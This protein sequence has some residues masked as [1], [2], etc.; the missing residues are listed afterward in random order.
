MVL[1]WTAVL[2]TASTILHVALPAALPAPLPAAFSAPSNH[3]EKKPYAFVPGVGV[4][5]GQKEVVHSTIKGKAVPVTRF[6]GIPYAQNPPQRFAAPQPLQPAFQFINATMYGPSCVQP[7][8][9]TSSFANESRGEQSESCLHL[10]IIKPAQARPGS[11]LP[12]M[13]WIYGGNLALGDASLPQYN[14]SSI[15]ANQDVIFVSFNYRLNIFGFSRSP[16]VPLKERNPGFLD[17]RL[18]LE[19]VRAN[20][21]AFGGCPDKVTVFGES[22]GGFSIQQLLVYPQKPL[23]YR[24][25]ILESRAFSGVASNTSPWDQAV[26][27]LGCTGSTSPLACMRSKDAQE[28]NKKVGNITFGPVNDNTTYA[29]HI[30]P[31]IA[32]GQTAK[33]P[34][35]L[36]TN[37]NEGTVLTGL[38]AAPPQ[39]I[40]DF[41]FTC[42]TG[43]LAAD[44]Q[45]AS[46]S[47]WRYYF[48][49]SFPNTTPFPDAGAYHSSEIPEVFGTYPTVGATAQQVAL[50]EYMQ[51]A[52]ARFAKDPVHGP[53]KDWPEYGSVGN[54]KDLGVNGSSSGPVIA[55]AS[56][57]GICAAY[58]GLITLQG[59]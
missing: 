42:T 50:S 7:V 21:V 43:L 20:I 6:L 38:V 4:L 25:V 28:I 49:A 18:A 29:D 12:V 14:G 41:A 44:L 55:A 19:W 3:W 47:V 27:S 34:V 22:A 2:L 48:N 15:V 11:S 58:N 46:Y 57:Q 30:S 26:A 24:A 36:G 40:T 13:V 23:P 1:F 8:L 56:I 9:G 39:V 10:N 16:E 31:L 35:L 45:N 33:V 37:A 51:T 52:W 5:L 53:A 59:Y 32:A 17:Q 54:I